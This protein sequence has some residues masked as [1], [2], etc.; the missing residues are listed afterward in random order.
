[1]RKRLLVLGITLTLILFLHFAVSAEP[2]AEKKDEPK[3][4]AAEPKSSSDLPELPEVKI[5]PKN[6]KLYEESDLIVEGR[7]MKIAHDLSAS[8]DPKIPYYAKVTVTR[9]HKGNALIKEVI[10][11]FP[12]RVVIKEDGKVPE[13]KNCNSF[14]AQPE[15]DFSQLFFLKKDKTDQ[16]YWAKDKDSIISEPIYKDK[17]DRKMRETRDWLTLLKPADVEM[18]SPT[19]VIETNMGPLVFTLSKTAKFTLDNFID[20]ARKGFYDGME[21]QRAVP[22]YL[23]QAGRPKGLGFGGPGYSLTNEKIMKKIDAPLATGGLAM[24]TVNGTDLVNGCQFF[25]CLEAGR[26][27]DKSNY[28]IIGNANPT[29]WRTLFKISNMPTDDKYRPVDPII[30]KSI[31]ILEYSDWTKEQKAADEAKKAKEKEL[32]AKLAEGKERPVAVFETSKGKIEFK[33]YYNIAPETVTRIVSMIEDG[34]YTGRQFYY[35]AKDKGYIETGEVIPPM[36]SFIWKSPTIG[37]E[38]DKN[39]KF[40]KGIVALVRP[41]SDINGGT[42]QIFFSMKRRTDWD[43]KYTPFGKVISSEKPLEEILDVETTGAFKPLK[44]LYITKAAID[45]RNPADVAADEYDKIPARKRYFAVVETDLGNIEFELF[46][47]DAPNTVENF[48]ALANKKFYDGLIFHRIIK[49]EVV[50]G[51][52]PVGDASDI[53]TI[54]FENNSRK[55]M[56]GTVAMARGESLDSASTQFYFSVGARPDLDKNKYTIFGQVTKGMDVVEKL[57]NVETTGKLGNPPFKPKKD[58]KMNKVYIVERDKYKTLD[59]ISE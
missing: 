44:P 58:V 26:D 25:I 19:A 24:A 8:K 46:K 2:E 54:K 33:F 11:A 18:A 43:G 37:A 30:I 17:Y 13:V 7:V 39:V 20:L 45:W 12:D 22:N 35:V 47:E 57:N 50:Q 9:V 55:H 38:F 42:T 4:E 34:F 41:G 3:K 23:L 5:D 21:I 31:K 32:L 16:V 28:P 52:A 56:K 48:I 29:Y 40:D 10:L 36:Y 59:K 27:L 49:G 15:K 6:K 1:M 53:K 51:G 14:E